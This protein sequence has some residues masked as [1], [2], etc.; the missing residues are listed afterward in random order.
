MPH[1]LLFGATIRL[2]A[3]SASVLAVFAMCAVATGTAT[4][5]CVTVR[6][7]P[8]VRVDGDIVRLADVAALSVVCE[9]EM[10]VAVGA[11]VLGDAPKPGG[12][13]LLS[14]AD[15]REQLYDQQ[16]NLADVRLVGSSAVRVTRT[17]PAD[18]EPLEAALSAEDPAQ[19]PTLEAAIRRYVSEQLADLGGAPDVQF[20]RTQSAA[21]ALSLARPEYDFRIRSSNVRDLGLVSF[22]VEVLRGG[23]VA[24][25]VPI[26]AQVALVR[27]VVVAATTI[28]RA[29]VIDEQH[30]VRAE[31]RFSRG[32]HLGETSL[33][34]IVGQEARR[35]VDRGELVTV[36]DVKSVP[37]VRRG[38]L[39]TVWNCSGS[40]RLKTVGKALGGGCLGETVE[41]KSERSGRRYSA[42]ITGPGTVETISG[43]PSAALASAG[44]AS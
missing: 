34:R 16:I 35:F 20:S 8:E 4:A 36:R 12:R 33:S 22:E 6:L 3:R 41:I 38:D 31:R 29:Q 14:V 19:I 9:A 44:D 21:Q 13:L 23:E 40:V 25:T 18:A 2:V 39:V 32:D 17:M 27:K 10:Y 24:Q 30:V 1:E 37:L 43:G 26:L 5:Q 42:R 7:L 11:V 28:N 15:V